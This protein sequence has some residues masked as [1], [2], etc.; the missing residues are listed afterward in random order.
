MMYLGSLL[1]EHTSI[2]YYEGTL[3]VSVKREKE[4]LVVNVEEI[5][6]IIGMYVGMNKISST[7]KKLGFDVTSVGKESLAVVVPLFRHDI[8]HMQDISEEIVRM[9]GIGNIEAKA[10]NF[11]EQTRLNDTTDR[12]KAKKGFRNRAVGA[13]YYENV[14]YVFSDKTL[15][16]KYGF[17]ATEEALALTNPI[18]EELNTLRSTILVN[19][20]TAVKRNVS[21]SIKS[22]PLFEMGAVFGSKREQS[23]AMAFVFSGQCEGENIGNAGKP[24]NIDFATFTQKVGAVIGAFELVPCTYENGL[25]HP[26]QSANIVVDD[27]VCGFMSKL[28]PTVQ[29]DFGIP[30]TFIAELDFDV[31][32]PKHINATPISKFQGVFKDLSVVIEKSMGYYEVAKVL[33][34]LQL[35]MLKDIY[36]VDIYEDEKLGDKKS[37]TIRFLIQSMDKTLEDA[38]I[39]STMTSIMTTLETECKAELR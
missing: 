26:Y 27:K 7:L 13:G 36:P 8:K 24:Q 19:L 11:T 6:D 1:A 17:V 32:M 33:N 29:E 10:L 38:D 3:D 30:D 12:Y 39:E 28:H 23:E 31:L 2:T 15:L 18:A 35:P 20:L 16:Q 25:I 14:S 22:I 37:L 34:G 4:T 5:S 21:Y 9:I